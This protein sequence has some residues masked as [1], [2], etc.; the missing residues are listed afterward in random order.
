MKFA[1]YIPVGGTAE[2]VERVY[3]VIDSVT[4]YST[5]LRWIVI[6]DDSIE[7]RTIS[8]HVH[9]SSRAKLI[10]IRNPRHGNGEGH[11]GGLCVAD[12]TAFKYIHKETDAQYILKLDTDSLVI[13]SFEREIERALSR[14]P[15][16]GML[17]VIG[18]SF[19][20]NR[21]YNFLRQV[22]K[23]CEVVLQIPDEFHAAWNCAREALMFLGVSDR[24][25]FASV[26]KLKTLIRLAV[27]NGYTLGQYCQGGGYVVTRTLLNR[28]SKDPIFADPSPFGWLRMGEDVIVGLSCAAM[29]LKMYDLSKRGEP[30]AI[31]PFCL[32]FSCEELTLL[33]RSI[34]HSI[35]GSAEVQ[36]RQYFQRRR[37][38]AE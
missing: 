21:T 20:E 28:I 5:M 22:A 11:S 32:P 16:V 2:E 33:E 8:G 13:S 30:F 4:Y 26:K 3:D 31:H 23:T 18:D 14:L 36:Y 9:L 24:R 29:G 10:V 6:V 7:P 25:K 38:R 1:A 15:D 27:S 12:F 37:H 35:K 19:G 17:G 34:V